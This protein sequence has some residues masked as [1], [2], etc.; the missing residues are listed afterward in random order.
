MK[1]NKK[2]A[3]AQMSYN[4]LRKESETENQFMRGVTNPIALPETSS[5]SAEDFHHTYDNK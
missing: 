2:N 1:A 5:Y 4:V 3:N